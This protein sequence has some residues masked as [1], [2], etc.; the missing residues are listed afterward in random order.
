MMDDIEL[1]KACASKKS[2]NSVEAFS[3]LTARHMNLVYSVALRYVSNPPQAKE[4]TQAVFI[5]LA[6]KARTLGPETILSAWLFHIAR[7]TTL[8]FLQ[9][10]VG[11]VHRELEV[12]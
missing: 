11:R 2:K 7:L 12:H 6:R 10:E 5:I 4:I 8:Y 9:T 1:L 3:T